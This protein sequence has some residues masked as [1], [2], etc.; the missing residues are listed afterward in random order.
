MF[1]RQKI[2]AS[3][4][5]NSGVG[6]GVRGLA[7]LPM[8]ASLAAAASLTLCVPLAL[9]DTK[10]DPFASL[11][12]VSV[13]FP[14][15]KRLVLEDPAND[16]IGLDEIPHDIRSLAGDAVVAPETNGPS[17]G[18]TGVSLAAVTAAGDIFENLP[19]VSIMDAA[20]PSSR[21]GAG[22]ADAVDTVTGESLYANYDAPAPVY[23]Q[24]SL[25]EG[26]DE[27]YKKALDRKPVPS[28]LPEVEANDL[29][30]DPPDT[31]E[32]A[33]TLRDVVIYT[34][35]NNPDIGIARWQSEDGRY[36]VRGAKAPFRP[37][38]ELTGR[39][40]LESLDVENGDG[41]Y[42]LNRREA[43]VRLTQ[44]LYD[45]GRSSQLLKR[46]KALYQS[47]ELS[48]YDTVEDTV[49]RAVTVYLD[50]LATG[51]LLANAKQNVEEH[52]AI[53]ELVRISYEG[54]NIS[55]A[56]LKRASTRLDRARTTAIDFENRL[57]QV[58]GDFRNI[59][60]LEPGK[61]IEP[62]V[63]VAS[64]ERLN[65]NTVDDIIASHFAVQAFVR[66]GNSLTHQL[67]AAKRAY[68]PELN[69]EVSGRYQD[70]V[71]GNTDYSTEGRALLSATWNLYDGGAAFNRAKQL[72]ARKNENDQR[73]VKQ[74]NELKQ[75][76]R[77]IVSV[78]RTTDDKRAIFDEQV[79][80]STRVIDLYFKQFEAGRRTLLELLDAQADLAEA[81]EESIANKFENLSA[82]FAS[83]RFQNTLTPTLSNQL[84][85][86]VPT[87]PEG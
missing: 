56:E 79:E 68:L 52:E 61:L 1:Q 46:A 67:N 21:A 38:V 6:N 29:F 17:G 9:A 3:I 37:S 70:N 51:D 41:V 53:V 4:G 45:F 59:T 35:K 39:T 20:L 74:R 32:D 57:E 44:R 23:K 33:L 85:F 28:T 73:I 8:A 86:G 72:R 80:S 34:L 18:A 71:L 60:G 11:R 50:L 49:F 12:L 31:S 13:L 75:E 58:A 48:Y 24:A 40:G 42:G 78:L 65:E 36:A 84:D 54:G 5:F 16:L 19:L 83:M 66:D 15:T 81:R 62:S 25:L 10:G 76:A 82:S 64:A 55:E 47:R 69:V 7:P 30:F 26:D 22:V 77:N 14:P 2:L 27:Q 87:P 63:D 43:S